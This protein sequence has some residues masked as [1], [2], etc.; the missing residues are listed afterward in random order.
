M[1]KFWSYSYH[2]KPHCM[3]LSYYDCA[4]WAISSHFEQNQLFSWT[5]SQHTNETEIITTLES[6]MVTKTKTKPWQMSFKYVKILIWSI[7]CFKQSPNFRFFHSHGNFLRISS[8]KK[9][10]PKCR[11]FCC[12]NY[13]TNRLAVE[14]SRWSL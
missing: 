1:G 10:P 11:I 7:L 13:R 12:R 8:L 2:A 6:A 5:N 9:K 4:V 3:I 14:R